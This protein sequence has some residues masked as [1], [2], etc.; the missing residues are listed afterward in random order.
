MKSGRL[1]NR[2][3]GLSW[4]LLRNGGWQCITSSKSIKKCLLLL[5]K[6]LSIEFFQSLLL[7]ANSAIYF[8]LVNKRRRAKE[9]TSSVALAPSCVVT[10]ALADD[11]LHITEP[12]TCHFGDT[13]SRR[14]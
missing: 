11:R 6:K 1:G 4:Q 7:S 14:R 5:E 13:L 12:A 8:T 3:L 10:V 9:T 2:A